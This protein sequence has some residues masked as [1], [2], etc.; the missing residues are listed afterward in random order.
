MPTNKKARLTNGQAVPTFTATAVDGT[1]IDSS[2]LEEQYTL[3]SFFRYAGCPFC[4]L[5]LIKLVERY[6][7]FALR[8]LKVVAFFQSPKSDVEE[9][10]SRRQPPFQIVADP[11]KKIYDLFRVES[12]KV[13]LLASLPAAATVGVA[14]AQ[15]KTSQPKITGDSFLMPAQFLVGPDL[16]LRNTHYG[17]NF[18][19]KMPFIDIER[20]LLTEV[21]APHAHSTT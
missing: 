6:Q 15:G 5:T 21:P 17:T 10:V 2:D 12:S 9:Y 16:T 11:D 18:G 4:D 20:I 3:L 14:I 19:D 1:V 7:N 13:G 8:G